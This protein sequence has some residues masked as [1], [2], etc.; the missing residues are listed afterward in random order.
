MDFL[1]INNPI[2]NILFLSTAVN[3]E[4][5]EKLILSMKDKIERLIDHN[6]FKLVDIYTITKQCN[7][8]RSFWA[9]RRNET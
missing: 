1:A 5:R 2:N 7:T 9:H 8:L 6:V 3:A 4:D